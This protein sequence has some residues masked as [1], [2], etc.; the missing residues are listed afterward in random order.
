VRFNIKSRNICFILVTGIILPLLTCCGLQKELKT[1]AEKIPAQID[2]TKGVLEKYRKEFDEYRD[3]DEYKS[4]FYRYASADR[5][6]WENNFALSADEIKRAEDIYKNSVSPILEKNDRKDEQEL[7]KQLGRINDALKY[8]AKLAKKT[9]LRI[10]ELHEAKKNA[11]KMAEQAKA[12]YDGINTVFNELETHVHNA[13]EQ[14]P[15]K[16]DDL[17]TRLLWFKTARDNTEKAEAS[18]TY[19][20]ESSLPDYAVFANN[21]LLLS[22]ALK[23]ITDRDNALRKKISELERDYSKILRDMK[24]DEKPWMEEVKYQWNNWSDFDTTREM[25]RRKR[26]ISMDDYNRIIGRYGAEG[27]IMSRGSDYEIWVEEADIEEHYY[28]KYL[29]V[30]NDRES[31]T[32][33]V[34]VSEKVY[35]ANEDNLN[36]SIVS[37]PFGYYE[38]EVINVATPPGFDKVGNPRYGEWV[39]NKET[40]HR[41]W[42]FF[43]RYLFWHMVLN[44]IGPRN[45]YYTY[46]R[47]NDWNTNYRG[48]RAYYG[49]GGSDFGSA[50][51]TTSANPKV[52]SSTFAKSGGFK[53][54]GSSVRGA[55]S[56]VRGRGP[57]SGK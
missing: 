44:G 33:W 26:Y 48:R 47:W 16:K 46:G 29:I 5:E 45:N 6:S 40:G 31:V 9:S 50:G 34:E 7:R 36:M 17:N 13:Q 12:D 25:Y 32:D 35:D 20:M 49:T 54:A 1:R 41:E 52:R 53:A 10:S 38:D 15:N 3:T 8:G 21:C 4:D 30:E 18:V 55:G 23:D 2:E 28:H 19:E 24:I 14:F 11:K 56:S 37:K 57:G 51:R 27:G 42:S 39:E 43:Q 22:S